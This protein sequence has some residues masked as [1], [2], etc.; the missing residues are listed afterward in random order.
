MSA[1]SAFVTPMPVSNGRHSNITSSERE[2]IDEAPLMTTQLT[3]EQC[4]HKLVEYEMAQHS[5][6]HHDSL[7]WSVSTLTW[8]VSSVLLGFVLSNITDNGLGVVI[9]LFCFIGIFLI[10]CSWMFSRQFRSIRNQKYRRCKELEQE[11]GLSQHT[12]TVHKNGS[13]SAMYSVIMLLFITT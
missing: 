3:A 5:A 1:A 7:V 12:N 10:L 11:L 6:E 9:L 13:Q 8:G 4:Q 2:V